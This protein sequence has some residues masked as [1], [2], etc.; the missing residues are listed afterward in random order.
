MD[1]LFE[2]EDAIL[3]V[4]GWVGRGP[5]RRRFGNALLPR[6]GSSGVKGTGENSGMFN[7][8]PQSERGGM[9]AWGVFRRVLSSRFAP[10]PPQWRT[11][12]QVDPALNAEPET[13]IE[14]AVAFGAGFK[15]GRY[16]FLVA[17]VE[18]SL[19]EQRSDAPALAI[20]TGTGEGQ[21]E[22][23]RRRMDPFH[24]ADDRERSRLGVLTGS[25]PNLLLER[26]RLSLAHLPTRREPKAH[27]GE[28]VHRVRLVLPQRGFDEHAHEQG[29]DLATALGVGK[30]PETGRIIE[31]SK[32]EHVCQSVPLLGD[33]LACQGLGRTALRIGCTIHGELDLKV[34]SVKRQGRRAQAAPAPG[35]W[36]S[37]CDIRRPGLRSDLV[38]GK[39]SGVEIP[40]P[41]YIRTEDGV[42][43]AYQVVGEGSVDISLQHARLGFAIPAAWP[44]ALLNRWP[45]DAERRF[46]TSTF[47]TLHQGIS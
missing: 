23:R 1:G 4:M 32:C 11:I 25:G 12:W 29:Q 5:A 43:I 35:A 16:V 22:V 45:E 19:D 41:R 8:R 31:Q 42:Y 14:A 38:R 40:D 17:A 27:R 13:F 37:G 30:G 26:H 33:H 39:D 44:L 28:I 7:V 20:G 36:R 46:R 3:H 21:V 10:H 6:E 15:V 18:Y 2:G 9:I 47:Q 34:R 24:Q